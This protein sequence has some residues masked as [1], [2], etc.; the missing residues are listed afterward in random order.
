MPLERSHTGIL[1]GGLSGLTVAAHLEHDCEVLEADSRPG[2]HCMSVV[3]QGLTFDAGGPHIVFSRNADTLAF[4]LSL[5]DGNLGRGRRNNKIFYN[6]RYVKY[7]FENGLFDLA[8]QDRFECLRDYIS[9][10]HRA[11]ANFK[12][13]MYHTFGTAITEK[14][15]LP[16]NEKIWKVPAEQMSLDW[17]E[18]RI[19][20]P[21]LEDVIKAAVG[22]ETEG[23]QHQL[24]FYYPERGGIQSLPD[25][26]AK[27]VR[28]LT[29]NFCVRSVRRTGDGWAVSDG[30]REYRYRRLVSTLPINEMAHR[31]EGVPDHIK[32]CGDSLRFNSLITITIGLASDLL[33]DYSAIYVPSPE[34]PFHRLSFPAVFSRQNAP[35]GKSLIQ[36]EITCMPGEGMWRS[37]DSDILKRVV[38][39]LRAMDLIHPEEICYAKVIRTKYGYVVQDFTYR[40]HLAEL[41]SY[42]ERQGVALCGRN[43]QF[44]YINMDQ[45]IESAQKTAARL[46]EAARETMAEELCPQ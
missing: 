31:F 12:D 33:P 36:A 38:E 42:F 9:N 11:P 45:C 43:A 20:R 41:K 30:D 5:L 22:V 10:T 44:E 39:G 29:T 26:M 15:L 2:G 13:W 6:G 7:P 46:N 4:M 8:P 27:R 18:G 14:Y 19:P 16:Y 34:L 17:V 3:E 24:F 40:K 28:R 37:D 35:Q 25:S 21:P 23:Y 32:A 1:G